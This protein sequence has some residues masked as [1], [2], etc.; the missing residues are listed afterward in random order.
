MMD[1]LIDILI[2]LVLG[3]FVVKVI[4]GY[5]RAKL[6]RQINEAISEMQEIS[7]EVKTNLIVV[8]V[9]KYNDVFYLYDRDTNEFIAQGK[10]IEEISENCQ[11]RFKDKTIIADEDV[12]REFGLTD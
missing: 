11:K 1:L 5:Q 12:L 7:K 9:E 2:G 8:N 4:E 6:K 10:T 3:W